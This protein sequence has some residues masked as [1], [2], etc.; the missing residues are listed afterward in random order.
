MNNTSYTQYYIPNIRLHST[1]HN[2]RRYNNAGEVNRVYLYR[3]SGRGGH[4]FG[5]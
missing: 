1:S 2:Q 5:Q 4:I 3:Y